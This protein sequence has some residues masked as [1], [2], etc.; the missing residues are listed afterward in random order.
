MATLMSTA[1]RLPPRLC[2]QKPSLCTQKPSDNYECMFCSKTFRK[3]Y[4][5]C[6]S[7]YNISTTSTT[8]IIATLNQYIMLL[9]C[10]F[11]QFGGCIHHALRTMCIPYLTGLNH[12]LHYTCCCLA[13]GCWM[14]GGDLKKRWDIP[15]CVLYM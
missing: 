3:Y 13:F 8:S 5:F 10:T 4:I 9:Y 12:M 6:G 11:I 1:L 15:G 14:G 2:T 7:T